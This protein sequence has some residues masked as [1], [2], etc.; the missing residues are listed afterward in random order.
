LS[1][2]DKSGESTNFIYDQAGRLIK[3]IYSD[4]SYTLSAYNAQGRVEYTEDELGNRTTYTYWPGGSQKEI[5]AANGGVTYHQ[6]NANGNLTLIRDARGNS[7]LYE[8]DALN[9]R[10]YTRYPGQGTYTQTHYNAQGQVEWEQD[11]SGNK[12]IY[13]Y[14]TLGRLVKV[15]PSYLEPDIFWSYTYYED[16]SLKTQKDARGN[17]TSYSYN[18]MGKR[19]SRKLP[20]GQI[21]SYSYYSDGTLRTKTD[22]NG[23]TST[24]YLESASGRVARI[25]RP[26][27]SDI[28]YTYYP[29]GKRWIM[30][31]ESGQTVYEYYP[32]G[33]LKSKEHSIA[34]KINYTYNAAGNIKS[35]ST[36]TINGVDVEYSYNAQNQLDYVDD[37]KNNISKIADYGYDLAGNLETVAYANK[38]NT[39]YQYNLRNQL[40]SIEVSKESSPV[41]SYTY[42]LRPEGNRSRVTENTGKTVNWTYDNLYR[43]TSETVSSS[44]DGRNGFLGYTYDSVGNRQTRSSTLTGINNQAYTGLYDANDRFTNDTYDNNGNPIASGSDSY[45]YDAE[46]RL[47]SATVGGKSISIVYDGDGNRVSK[48]VDGV[49]TTYLVDTNNLTGYS[50]V[51]EE[52]RA[53]ILVKAY[54]YGLDLVS[55][56]DIPAAKTYYFG[57]D[58]QGSVRYLTDSDGNVTDTYDYDAFGNLLSRTGTTDNNYLY[59]GEQWDFDLEMY[60]LRARYMDTDSG[61]F[62]GMDSF[63]GSNESP[64]SL[65][66]YLYAN[67]NPVMFTDPSGLFS[68][69]EMNMTQA[70][71][72]TLYANVIIT[73]GALLGTGISIAEAGSIL[74]D[75]LTFSFKFGSASGGY[76]GGGGFNVTIDRRTH[77]VAVGVTGEFGIAAGSLRNTQT[78]KGVMWFDAGFVFGMSSPSQMASGFSLTSYWPKGL[79]MA[80]LRLIPM[81]KL[82]TIVGKSLSPEGFMNKIGFLRNRKSG[83]T[84]MIQVASGGASVIG[85]AGRPVSFATTVGY[86]FEVTNLPGYMNQQVDKVV[87]KGFGRSSGY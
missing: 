41:L 55:C 61:R 43:L 64:A 1:H 40:E 57:Y 10:T 11:E 75:G 65:H 85:L 35:V 5:I 33:R 63:E 67:A 24:Y 76:M 8:Y 62:W 34:G 31:D 6:Y 66:K 48:T 15:T 44:P 71:M 14:D 27:Y 73:G 16:G 69:V 4:G 51:L 19:I 68:M 46:N 37:R 81:K 45:Q 74:P 39:T 30:S 25:S 18:E 3:T 58:G 13:Q 9:R 79:S 23:I 77:K 52:K 22:F 17:V 60:F 2:R 20:Q 12:K 47:V 28:S 72:G 38:I 59:T 26:G 29:D 78:T 70:V 21:E 56:K 42:T 84:I 53:G 83:N 82:S 87:K 54:T 86:S 80:A 7:V 32:R 36:D 49:T 50:Q